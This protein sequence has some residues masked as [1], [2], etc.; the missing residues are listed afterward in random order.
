M[1]LE[2]LEDAIDP[3]LTAIIENQNDRR[4]I[5]NRLMFQQDGAPPH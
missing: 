3:A 1:Y 5:A 4:Y 2:L